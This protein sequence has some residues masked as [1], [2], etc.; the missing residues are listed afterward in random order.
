MDS[1]LTS[2]KKKL[3]ITESYVHF[4]EQIIMDINTALMILGQ[5]GVGKDG[6]S[7]TTDEQTWDDFLNNSKDLEAA[8]TY[9]YLRVRLVF[10]PPQNASLYEAYK[11]QAEELEWRLNVKAETEVS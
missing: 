8:K 1:I 9:V 2:I 7:I 10:D 3:G 4:D 6:Y 5:I 11:K